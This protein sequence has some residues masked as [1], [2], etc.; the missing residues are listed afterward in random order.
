MFQSVWVTDISNVYVARTGLRAVAALV[1]PA[2]PVKDG[3]TVRCGCCGCGGRGNRSAGTSGRKEDG[4]VGKGGEGG[5]R[6]NTTSTTTSFVAE[7]APGQLRYPAVSKCGGTREGQESYF[8]VHVN[9]SLL[10]LGSV[11]SRQR[12]P[13]SAGGMIIHRGREQGAGK[14]QR[15]ESQCDDCMS[16]AS[17]SHLATQKGGRAVHNNKSVA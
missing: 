8:C 12:W 14:L 4:E 7:K 11:F 6:A 9:V 17:R 15:P 2:F 13:F 5:R 1:F 3:H 10:L 16:A